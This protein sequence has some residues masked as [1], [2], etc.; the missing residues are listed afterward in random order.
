MLWS[1]WALGRLGRILSTRPDTIVD[2]LHNM[3]ARFT[4][5]R[6]S[7]WLAEHLQGLEPSDQRLVGAAVAHRAMQDTFTVTA[8]GV[9]A[10]AIDQDLS[11]WPEAY[12]A[13]L[14]DGLFLDRN[15]HLDVNSDR[16]QAAALIIAPHPQAAELLQELATKIQDASFA[17][18]F[19]PPQQYETSRAMNSVAEVVPQGRARD[20]WS[21][22]SKHIDLDID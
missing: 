19:E 14:L 11:V 12:R 7:E 20:A 8:E 6:L 10:C 18:R 5:G 22:I 3:N 4:R 15:G 17:Y 1:R 9:D 16:G 13:G 2:S 21:R